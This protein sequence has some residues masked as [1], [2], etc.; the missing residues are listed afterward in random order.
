MS[1]HE[2]LASKWTL[3]LILFQHG[4]VGSA[5]TEQIHFG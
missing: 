4:Y 3:L 1:A 5:T 2:I